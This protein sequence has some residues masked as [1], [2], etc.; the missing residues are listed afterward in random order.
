MESN[1]FLSYS[2]V[3]L[4]VLNTMCFIN[5]SIKYI[6]KISLQL[7]YASILR[8]ISLYFDVNEEALG[9]PFY[10]LAVYTNRDRIGIWQTAET[11]KLL[12]LKYAIQKL[13]DQTKSKRIMLSL[14]TV[15]NRI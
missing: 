14:L 6:A 4:Q 11:I 13:S 3:V 2:V 15:V 10:A 8:P 12:S 1:L 5:L 7:V 9:I